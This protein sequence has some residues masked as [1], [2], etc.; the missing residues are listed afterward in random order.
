MTPGFDAWLGIDWS[1]AKGRRLPGIQV[2]EVRADDAAP[3]LLAGP[4]KPGLWRR[5]D[6][7]NLL[8]ERH[9]GGERI[10]AGFDFAFAYAW[11]N[12]GTY[13]PGLAGAPEDVRSLWA[14]VD[15]LAGPSEDFYGGG[16]YAAGSPV[17]GLYLTPAG[18]GAGYEHRRRRTELACAVVTSPH[19][20]FKCVGA[21]NVGT[22]SLAGMRI[23]RQ[24]KASLG[25]RVTVW[26]F[27][28]GT[29]SGLT[30]VEIFPRLYFKRAGQDPRAWHDAAVVNATLSACGSR[31]MPPRWSARREDEADAVVSAA[32]L[33]ALSADAE[34]WRAPAEE[35]AAQSEG[36]IF[37]VEPVKPTAP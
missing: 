18:R 13:F 25:E 15:Q 24:L 22:G 33:R 5:R 11:H 37:G 7:L 12:H 17:A 4:Q 26:P 20:V 34:T 36:W 21:A 28:V 30:V 32:A 2:A 35:P 14:Y 1:G 29:P 23:L 10:L 8:L 16:V 6:V 3:R 31:A 19:P 9:A 27:D